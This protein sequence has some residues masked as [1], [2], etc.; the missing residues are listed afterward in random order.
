MAAC[1]V[2]LLRLAELPAGFELL[3]AESEQAGLRFL[4]RLAD[5]WASGVNRFDR[6]GEGLFGARVGAQL[7]AVGGLNVDPYATAPRVGRVRHVYVL[8]RYRR[9]GVGRHLVTEIIAAAHG[10]FDIL[11]LSTPNTA[12]A[13]L[14]ERLGFR[15]CPDDPRCTH[16]LDLAARL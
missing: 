5:E 4:G 16:V 12:A 11:R 8:A 13:R 3:Q 10:R 9:R 6:S 2:H 15:P 1:D 14:Y 7:V